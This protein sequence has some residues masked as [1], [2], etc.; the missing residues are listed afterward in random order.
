MVTMRDEQGWRRM[1]R[2]GLIGETE[3]RRI[4]FV[5]GDG[6]PLNG[7]VVCA[8]GEI[9]GEVCRRWNDW[10]RKCKSASVLR[11]S[12]IEAMELLARA[13]KR[14]EIANAEGDPILSAWLADAKHLVDSVAN[15]PRGV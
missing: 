12:L 2:F 5:G 10:P 3:L 15:D 13:A 1:E 14:V 9:A 7:D 4:R 11:A 6:F 8:N